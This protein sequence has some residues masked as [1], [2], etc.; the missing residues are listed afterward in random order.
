MMAFLPE[1]GR[2]R[3]GGI[4]SAHP[5]ILFI[6]DRDAAQRSTRFHGF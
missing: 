6:T 5:R 2:F 4:A 3:L 1:R